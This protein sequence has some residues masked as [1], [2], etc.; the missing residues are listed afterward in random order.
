MLDA[1]LSKLARVAVLRR[2]QRHELAYLI[3]CEARSP[4]LAHD[5]RVAA[6]MMLFASV[7]RKKSEVRY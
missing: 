1:R 4:R 3:Q 2:V 6:A 7:H 5:A